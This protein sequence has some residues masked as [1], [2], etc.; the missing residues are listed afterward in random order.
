MYITSLT[1]KKQT[2]NV[3]EYCRVYLSTEC[4]LSRKYRREFQG[5]N[6]WWAPRY[7][8]NNHSSGTPRRS[9]EGKGKWWGWK[10]GKKVGKLHRKQSAYRIANPMAQSTVS[11]SSGRVSPKEISLSVCVSPRAQTSYWPLLFYCGR[12]VFWSHIFSLIGSAL[13]C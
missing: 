10:E 3:D 6:I 2:R 12:T 13:L 7:K 11:Y 1:T 5:Q 4:S 9:L 8:Q